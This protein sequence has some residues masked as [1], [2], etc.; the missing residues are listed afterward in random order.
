MR[1]VYHRLLIFLCFA[2]IALFAKRLRRW[3]STAELKTIDIAKKEFHGSAI[4]RHFEFK[5]PSGKAKFVIHPLPAVLDDAEFP[6]R[7]MSGY[8]GTIQ[9]NYL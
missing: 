7:L 5:R 1:K 6:F 4:A 2:H 9:F 3:C 8:G